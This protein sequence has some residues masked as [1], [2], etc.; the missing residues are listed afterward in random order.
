MRISAQDMSGAASSFR[1]GAVAEQMQRSFSDSRLRRSEP[2]MMMA[3]SSSSVFRQTGLSQISLDA[4]FAPPAEQAPQQP[5]AA[6]P[7]SLPEW[8]YDA[9]VWRHK[10]LKILGDLDI[11]SGE[12][13]DVGMRGRKLKGLLL[14]RLHLE[15][16]K[17]IERERKNFQLTL[18]EDQQ[19]KLDQL[20]DQQLKSATAS[21]AS[22]PASPVSAGSRR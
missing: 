3:A 11:E 14:Q 2:T 13:G 20:Q 4:G 15:D 8:D 22:G 19:L 17:A 16:L 5:Q 12:L 10:A 18:K 9:A 6:Q 1:S 7:P 21:P